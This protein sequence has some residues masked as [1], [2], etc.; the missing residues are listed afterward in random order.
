MYRKLQHQS[1]HDRYHDVPS[2]GSSHPD[3]SSP[4][5]HRGHH[6]TSSKHDNGHHTLASNGGDQVTHSRIF[7]SSFSL[8]SASW[9]S[10]FVLEPLTSLH[11]S[12]NSKSP[13]SR[14]FLESLRAISACLMA[15]SVTSRAILQSSI[16]RIVCCDGILRLCVTLVWWHQPT[17][18]FLEW[19][20]LVQV[21]R[22][23]QI[24]SV[25]KNEGM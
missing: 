13:S 14:R 5:G 11:R 21:L 25:R 7:N 20:L 10:K 8:S 12:L 6:H 19:D 2:S 15:I 24:Q 17:V 23:S 9:P 1:L 3:A 18:D 16:A 4:S 22:G